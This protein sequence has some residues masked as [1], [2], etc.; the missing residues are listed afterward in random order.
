MKPEV[1]VIMPAYN[2]QSYISRAI[3]S[4]YSQT[5]QD[6]ELIIINDASIDTTD[7]I[8]RTEVKGRKNTVYLQH[9]KNKGLS[10]T[11]NT[12]IKKAKGEYVAF[13]DS[14]DAWLPNFLDEQ[15]K[16]INEK[17]VDLVSSDYWIRGLKSVKKASEINPNIKKEN[18][19]LKDILMYQ[20]AL[21]ST[22]LCKKEIL[23]KVDY[24]TKGAKGMEDL[25]MWV[26]LYKAGC[27][28]YIN[29]KVLVTYAD[30]KESI[31][32]KVL[33]DPE[34]KEEV[35]RLQGLM[36]KYGLNEV[37]KEALS[38]KI[39]K[40]VKE[41]L[42]LRFQLALIDKKYKLARKLIRKMHKQHN[43]RGYAVKKIFLILIPYIYRFITLKIR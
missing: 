40:R 15:L 37:E 30:N 26:K 17:H 20:S 11:R 41:I 19:I 8:I 34:L 29:K 3:R 31:S 1:S 22:V 2:V 28:F 4:V 13:L 38:R 6:F 16:L 42:F 7:E 5:F 36:E 35:G 14:D 32:N 10:E 18:I 27:R 33:S 12:G 25:D 21:P 39:S 43:V 9:K 23:R 24:F